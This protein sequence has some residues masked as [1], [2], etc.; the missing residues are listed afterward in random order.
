[1]AISVR[2]RRFLIG[3]V[4]VLIFGLVT[5]GTAFWRY[6]EMK[7]AIV[8]DGMT[9]HRVLSQRVD[10]HDAHMTGL[11]ALA[12]SAD[13]PPVD[14]I[15]QVTTSIVR[16]YPRIM[17]IDLADL[18]DEQRPSLLGADLPLNTVFAAMR[19]S[20][21]LLT[22]VPVE[23]AERVMLVK[24][25]PQASASQYLII[26]LIDL[27][28]LIATD[29]FGPELGPI[30]LLLEGRP[31]LA[32]P[33]DLDRS[34]IAFEAMLAS[35]TQ[36]LLLRIASPIRPAA[37]FPLEALALVAL[38]LMLGAFVV[39]RLLAARIAAKEAGA[40]ALLAAQDARLAH[41]SRVNAM[42]ELASGIAHEL[43]QPL[44]AI[45]SQC[46]AGQ[47][48]AQ[49][50]EAD[51]ASILA[52]FE[53]SARNAKR[54]GDILGKLRS[55]VTKGQPVVE[56]VDLA[57][58]VSDVVQ[59]TAAEAQA[60]AVIVEFPPAQHPA[61]VRADRVQLEQVVFNLVRNA[62]EATRHA[63]H[64]AR[65]TITLTSTDASAEINVRDNGPGFE[66][67]ALVRVFEPFFTTKPEGM[68]L[69]LSLCMTLVERYGGTIRAGNAASGGAELVVRLPLM[70]RDS[71][72]NLSEAA[73]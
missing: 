61:I 73:E 72:T 67:E 15:R 51:R 21:A 71:G 13:P 48:L 7:S 44:T 62:I 17:A 6:R 43:T 12:Q 49:R 70:A 36:P 52:A 1:V 64:P 58:L 27:R 55:W 23:G 16:F 54:A 40:R 37:L 38:G 45:L 30:Q 39:D 32:N 34:P 5:A 11:A 41:A 29:R 31:L 56:P 22:V 9:L 2:R 35:R 47:R 65:I 50:P 59:L 25:V 26:L 42:G 68:G 63:A 69:G 8:A 10:Q 28:R 20:K 53:A 57:H 3:L 4:A 18:T 14:A 19:H 24:R 33:G 60:H 66:P 46:Q